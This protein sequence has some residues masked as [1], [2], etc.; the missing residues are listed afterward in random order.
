MVHT[1]CFVGS[2]DLAFA[3]LIKCRSGSIAL[4][5]WQGDVHALVCLGLTELRAQLCSAAALFALT[6]L[7]TLRSLT[8]ADWTPG[9]TG[10]SGAV[11]SLAQFSRLTGQ[12]R[13][14][15]ILGP[16]SV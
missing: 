15:C 3:G 12:R 6:A 2:R 14:F 5:C 9:P 11:L 7:T 16:L 1:V 4:Q 10:S 8:V 13:A